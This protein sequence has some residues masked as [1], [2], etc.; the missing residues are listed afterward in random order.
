VQATNR[1]H[2]KSW[3]WTC[4]RYRARRNQT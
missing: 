4:S 2:T 3:E 1:S